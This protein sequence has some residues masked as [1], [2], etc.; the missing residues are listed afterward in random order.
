M[1][2]IS[3]QINKK[4]NNTVL[5]KI[6]SA[7]SLVLFLTPIIA[8]IVSYL[9]EPNFLVSILIFLGLPSLYISIRAPKYIIKSFVFSLI[10]SLPLMIILGY[11]GGASLAWAFPTSFFSYYL[12]GKVS[13]E[14][15]LWAFFNIYTVVILYEYIFEN[16]TKVN[17]WNKKMWTLVRYLVVW[18]VLFVILLFFTNGLIKIP[19]FYLVFGL[20]IFIFP[21]I[22]T[23]LYYPKLLPKIIYSLIY[24]SYLSLLYEI[25]ALTYGWWYFPGTN[26]IGHITLLNVTFPVEEFVFWI[27]LFAPAV[28]SAFEYLDDDCK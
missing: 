4:I 6:L 19:Y 20:I 18:I 16:H 25:A 11:I 22:M 5:K 3:K 14:V 27:I 13:I 1:L 17:I 23:W 15:M 21:I 12:F 28:I 24:F 10:A 7:D 8:V 26:F 9:F 2:P